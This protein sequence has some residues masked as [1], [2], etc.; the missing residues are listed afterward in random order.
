MVSSKR[1]VL[2]ACISL[3]LQGVPN[4]CMWMPCL[5]RRRRL[6]H[7]GGTQ[8]WYTE[9]HSEAQWSPERWI[10]HPWMHSRLGGMGLWAPDP[11]VGV[12]LHCK[13]WTRW[14]LRVPSSWNSSMILERHT[15]VLGFVGLFS[16]GG[17]RVFPNQKDL[18]C[19]LDIYLGMPEWRWANQVL[20]R[21]RSG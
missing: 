9:T 11:T 1:S 3:N 21:L 6:R 18:S 14:P 8:W 16:W 4:L 15:L 17:E 20:S 13:G 5:E 10:S 12:P 19:N 7:S 2:K